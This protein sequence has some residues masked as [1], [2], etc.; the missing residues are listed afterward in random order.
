MS[1]YIL[2]MMMLAM[3]F[4][5]S[6]V[7]TGQG[8]NIHLCSGLSFPIYEKSRLYLGGCSLVARGWACLEERE[9]SGA[10]WAS[11]AVGGSD[12]AHH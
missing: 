8:G 1:L 10:G 12:F 11:V 7:A 5:A 9:R 4:K 3:W 2:K 6:Y